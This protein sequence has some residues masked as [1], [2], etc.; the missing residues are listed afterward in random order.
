MSQIHISLLA[1]KWTIVTQF[2]KKLLKQNCL[3]WATEMFSAGLLL[4]E[5]QEMDR[6]S[7]SNKALIK[8]VGP[9]PNQTTIWDLD[10]NLPIRWKISRKIACHTLSWLLGELSWLAIPTFLWSAIARQRVYIM[11][12]EV[13]SIP[14]KVHQRKLLPP[15]IRYRRTNVPRPGHAASGTGDPTAQPSTPLATL[16]RNC[17]SRGRDN[18]QR[19][20]G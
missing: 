10:K 17:T 14:E 8:G 15:I 1:K 3:R 2:K 12:K 16:G 9:H 5:R 13:K 7:L 11:L 20:S 19:H 6:L 18:S 4:V